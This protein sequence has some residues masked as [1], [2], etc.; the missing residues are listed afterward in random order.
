MTI[1]QLIVKLNTIIIIKI[2]LIISLI[3][4]ISLLYL[5][6]IIENKIKYIGYLIFSISIILTLF[7]EKDLLFV[8]LKIGKKVILLKNVY[9]GL[10]IF[11]IIY[12]PISFYKEYMD[13][14][15]SYTYYLFIL[16]VIITIIFHYL[17]IVMLG[18]F[19]KDKKSRKENDNMEELINEEIKKAMINE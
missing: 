8:S 11:S 5:N 12:Y 1:Y 15:E 16:I 13:L 14:K 4:E 2:S 19:V 6:T 10:F 7:C 9:I 18:N 3:T 17:L